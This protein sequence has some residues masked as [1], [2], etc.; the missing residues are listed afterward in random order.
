MLD[1]VQPQRPAFV[2]E[3]R[4]DKAGR[5]GTLIQH[6]GIKYKTT[7]RGGLSH[8]GG[9]R[10]PPSTPA[11]GSVACWGLNWNG[12]VDGTLTTPLILSVP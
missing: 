3:A 2:G 12:E 4:R 11:A 9:D 10:Y 6:E 1:F 5:E 8:L 7:T